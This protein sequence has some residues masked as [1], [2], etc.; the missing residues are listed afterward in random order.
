M[1]LPEKI[2]SDYIPVQNRSYTLSNI[3]ELVYLLANDHPEFFIAVADEWLQHVSEMK[4]EDSLFGTEYPSRSRLLKGLSPQVKFL[5]ML[6]AGLVKARKADREPFI[7]EGAWDVLTDAGQRKAH[8][9][10]EVRHKE[11]ESEDDSDG[12]LPH[13][14][15]VDVQMRC[16]GEI[17]A[18]HHLQLEHHSHHSRTPHRRRND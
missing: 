6:E 7:V 2:P 3:C 1:S 4:Y 14:N 5:R 8:N 9:Q 13:P 18:H 16:I 17:H 11:T 12:M 10:W 15:L